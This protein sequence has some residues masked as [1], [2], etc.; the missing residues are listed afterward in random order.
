MKNAT[1]GLLGLA[2]LLAPPGIDA[3]TT[4]PGFN[5]T[6]LVNA[7]PATGAST[8]TAIAYEPG[9][10]NL[11][12][13]EK[14]DDSEPL[15]QARVRVRNSTTG[16]VSTAVT[17]GCVDHRGERGLLGIAFSPDYLAPGGASRFVYL[18][19]TR[20][21]TSSGACSLEVVSPQS[22]NQASRFTANGTLLGNELVL[23]EGPALSIS[24]STRLMSTAS[25]SN[26]GSRNIFASTGTK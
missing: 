19:Y 25:D 3:S 6:Q 22:R 7:T 12:V 24:D 10:G 2:F 8:P 1:L 20:I 18:Y 21:I 15:T 9:T 17:L 14:G 13:L 5:E 26:I 4:L 23:L 16:A 11:W